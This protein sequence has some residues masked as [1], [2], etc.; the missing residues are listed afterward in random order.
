VKKACVCVVGI[1]VWGIFAVAQTVDFPVVVSKIQITGNVEITSQEILEVVSIHPGDEIG[2]EDLKAASQAIY[3]LGWFSEVMPSVDIGG[4]IVFN[5]VE[6]PKV[7]KIEITG[8]VNTDAFELFGLTLFRLPIMPPNRVRGILREHGVRTGKLLNN[9]SLKNGLEAIIDAY[10]KKGY[11]LIMLG[12]VVLEEVLQIEIIEGRITNNLISGL[13]TVPYD[14]AQE[15][16]DLPLGECLKKTRVQQILTQ[17]NS[18]VYFSDVEITPQQGASQD[19]IELLWNLTERTLIDTP[20]AIEA[21]KLEGVT[22]FPQWLPE[23]TLGEIPQGPMGNYELLQIL[24]GLYDLYYRAGYV[25]VRFFAEEGDAGQLRLHVVEGRIG[26]V[27]LE[28]NTNTK[29]YVIMKNLEFHEGDVLNQQRLAVSQQRL[30]ALDYF[31]SVDFV[32]EWVDDTIHLAIVVVENDKLGGITGSLAYSPESGGVVGTVDYTQKNLLGTG[33]DLSVSYERGIISDASITW[34]LG[35]S[36]VSFFPDFNRV[37]FVLY[38]EEEEEETDDG[39]DTTYL[40]VGGTGSVSYPWADYTD[41]SLAYKREATREIESTVWEPLESLTISLSYDDTNASLFPTMGSRRSLSLEKA[42]GFTVGANFFKIDS[43]WIHFSPVQL[44]LP[45]LA[46]RDQVIATRLAL[47]WGVGDVPS[48]DA[49]D[50]GGVS[51]IRGAEATDATRLFY[52]NIEYRLAI[53]EGLAAVLFFD[54]GVDLDQI[55]LSESKSSFGLEFG[56]EVAGM[57][58]RLDIAWVFGPE[59][60]L[61]PSFDIGFSRMF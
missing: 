38:R 41:V 46:E 2:E 55:S 59:M 39:E 53:V 7:K 58:A 11:T 40:T 17:L 44:N 54:C 43:S 32:P 52:S 19:S 1:V 34:S 10:D 21:I 6:Y 13:V 30:I 60:G 35:Y 24:E 37:G 9:R 50:F 22:V 27:T 16:V 36:T 31:G 57:Y 29:D 15:L 48:S 5:V 47:G 14:L 61:M 56:V 23:A 28:G 3:D 42:G 20:L 33:Q 4:T 45:F 8:N 25:M 12:K 18:S 26:Q 51:T 49:Y